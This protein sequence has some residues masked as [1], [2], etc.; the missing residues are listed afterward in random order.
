MN[1]FLDLP[2]ALI[3]NHAPIL[4]AGARV[5]KGRTL[6]QPP[7]YH[8]PHQGVRH[9]EDELGLDDEPAFHADLPYR[10]HRLLA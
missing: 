9:R 4:L 7:R 5:V 1:E 2:L 3:H 10:A 6:R 8:K